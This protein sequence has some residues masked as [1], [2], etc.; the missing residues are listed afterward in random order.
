[1][2]ESLPGV[3]REIVDRMRAAGHDRPILKRMVDALRPRP[4]DD[5]RSLERPRERCDSPPCP[6]APAVRLTERIRPG[7]R[8]RMRFAAE[9]DNHLS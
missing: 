5:V 7:K 6:P 2:A 1:M 4:R 3:L 8:I 9:R